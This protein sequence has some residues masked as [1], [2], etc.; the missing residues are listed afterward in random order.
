M[1]Y[2]LFTQG[3]SYPILDGIPLYLNAPFMILQKCT[4]GYKAKLF[5]E[6]KFLVI[7]F[8]YLGNNTGP[9]WPEVLSRLVQSMQ[10][11]HRTSLLS[12]LL[13]F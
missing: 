10:L 6:A 13:S 3:A 2:K 11:G 12:T 7:I 8:T 4:M 9:N 5:Y 1:Q